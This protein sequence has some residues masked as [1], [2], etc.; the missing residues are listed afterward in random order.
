MNALRQIVDVKGESLN[1]KLPDNF[2]PGRVEVI[3]LPADEETEAEVKKT[4]N[5]ISTLRGKLNL[6]KEQYY[7]FQEDIKKSRNEWENN[8]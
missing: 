2:K 4:S 5:K 8:I 1:I 6:S 3:I 7:N